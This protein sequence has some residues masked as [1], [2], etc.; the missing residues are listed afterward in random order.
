LVHLT[1]H[2][3]ILRDTSERTLTGV[4]GVTFLLYNTE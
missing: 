3:G 4:T 1:N 2:N